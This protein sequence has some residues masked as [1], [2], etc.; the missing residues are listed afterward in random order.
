MDETDPKTL[1]KDQTDHSDEPEK[2]D[3]ILD[4]GISDSGP[5]SQGKPRTGRGRKPLGS[6]HDMVH[7]GKNKDEKTKED[8]EQK[9]QTKEKTTENTGLTMKIEQLQKKLEDSDLDLA[10]TKKSLETH[11]QTIR[12]LIQKQAEDTRDQETQDEKNR[13]IEAENVNLK[14]ANE[15][16][17]EI[18][19]ELIRRIANEELELNTPT[20]ANRPKILFLTDSNGRRIQPKINQLTSISILKHVQRN[21][22]GKGI[23]YIKSS[24]G[25]EDLKE[26][27]AIV[28]LLGTNDFGSGSDAK[29]THKRTEE[30][31]RVATMAKTRVFILEIPPTKSNIRRNIE[32]KIHNFKLDSLTKLSPYTQIIKYS[33]KI[34]RM[35]D[36]EIFKDELHIDAEGK[37]CDV[38]VQEI[39]NAIKLTDFGPLEDT[40]IAPARQTTARQA[41]TT[42]ANRKDKEIE[43]TTRVPDHATGFLIGSKQTNKLRLEKKHQVNIKIVSAH[44]KGDSL[45]V[46]NGQKANVE[47][48]TEDIKLSIERAQ[49]KS[50]QPQRQRKGKRQDTR[51]R[52]GSRNRSRSPLPGYPNLPDHNTWRDGG[53]SSVWAA[54]E[55]LRG[56]YAE[57]TSH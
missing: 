54:E 2:W 45:F 27:D 40:Q 36:A 31:V 38:I 3:R 33:E 46:V 11:E 47:A 23:E 22:L 44:D 32:G 26:A 8:K 13:T 7:G 29:Q 1:I 19:D 37:A 20:E 25:T 51:G 9:K 42:I 50:A 14:E 12:D 39:E 35:T 56:T 48:A 49:N 10:R 34:E 24:E 43:W 28:L 6:Y 21:N 18:N 30:L 57:Y 5:E 52:G 15:K 41:T 16:L 55:T 53:D 17:R 4:E